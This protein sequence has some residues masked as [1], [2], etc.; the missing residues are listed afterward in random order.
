MV[1]LPWRAVMRVLV[2]V[3]DGALPEAL[4]E[5]TQALLRAVLAAQPFKRTVA[6]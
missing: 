5:A 6:L 2:A 4:A 1:N 3:V